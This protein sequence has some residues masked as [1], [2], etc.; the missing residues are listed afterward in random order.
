MPTLTI[1]LPGD[2]KAR[3]DK[4]SKAFN[5]SAVC[6][7]AL[8]RE[9]SAQEQL[10]GDRKMTMVERLKVQAVKGREKAEAA[11]RAAGIRWAQHNASYDQL[12]ELSV[13][14]DASEGDAD[15]A[16]RCDGAIEILKEVDEVC[17]F[18]RPRGFTD[19]WNM[20]FLAGACEAFEAVREEVES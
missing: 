10:S 18:E 7:E 12:A 13:A 20:A 1:S 8:D 16:L 11:G 5:V 2:L 15:H 6:R 14:L 9:V 19:D 3:L 4:Q 17:G